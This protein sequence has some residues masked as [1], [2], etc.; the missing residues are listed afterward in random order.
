M[1]ILE[2]KK[3]LILG[4][5]NQKS[6]AWGIAQA[7]HREGARLG[8]NYLGDALEKRVR[9]LAESVNAELIEQLDVGDDAQIDTFFDKVKEKWGTVDFLV[10][11]IAFA[12]RDSLKGRFLDTS[13]DDFLL[14]LNISAYSLVAVAQRC[15]PLMESGGSLLTLS[16]LGS[17]RAVPN[18]NVMGVAKATLESC[19]RYLALDLGKDGIRV[20]AVSAGPL[21]TLAASGIGGFR[22]FLDTYEQGAPLRRNVTQDEVGNSAVYLLSE[23]SAGVTG[24]VHYVDAGFNIGIG[25]HGGSEG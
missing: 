7:A 21:R 19:V 8:F 1:G 15:A 22:A 12:N 10:H 9:P 25:S 17:V 14:A 16:Y 2:G 18:Y 3:G 20:N 13:R 5:A 11:S 23:W 6:I 24:E 4:V